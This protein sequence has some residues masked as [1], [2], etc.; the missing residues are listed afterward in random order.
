[1]ML[2]THTG[3]PAGM[4]YPSILPAHQQY[5]AAKMPCPS[6]A[7]DRLTHK[8]H[9]PGI[10]SAQLRQPKMQP[11]AQLS[12]RN[13][14]NGSWHLNSKL[15]AKQSKP[16]QL[17]ITAPQSKQHSLEVQTCDPRLGR[18]PTKH[19]QMLMQLMLSL[20]PQHHVQPSR[21]RP[22]LQTQVRRSPPCPLML[23]SG[24]RP[25]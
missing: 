20:L 5:S 19:V 7:G 16:K 25:C 23:H 21:P 6:T 4:H 9:H 11:Q 14:R 24:I 13:L 12:W 10:T 18:L 3:Q 2:A 17:A 15:M 22:A 1:M 8:L